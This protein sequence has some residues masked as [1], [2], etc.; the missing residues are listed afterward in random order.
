MKSLPFPT[1]WLITLVKHD[2]SATPEAGLTLIECIMAI[3]VVGI[4]GAA[5]APML[6]ISVATRINSQKSEQALQ[7]AQSEVDR[8]RVLVERGESNT[9]VLPPNTGDATAV[10]AVAAPN[11]LEPTLAAVNAVNEAREVDLDGDNEADFALQSY[12]TNQLTNSDGVPQAFDLGVRV[13]DIQ[14]FTS[15]QTLDTEQASLALTSGSADRRQKPLAVLSTTV[16]FSE[17]GQS[18]CNYIEF[19]DSSADKPLGCD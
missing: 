3:V 13:Y 18:F 17:S 19:A 16:A 1:A 14:A 5:I 12:T 4:V 9:A 10:T 2:R 11:T 15:G 8:I 6:V 7:L